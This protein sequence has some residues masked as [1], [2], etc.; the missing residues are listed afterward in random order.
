MAL[1]VL[2]MDVSIVIVSWN[3]KKHLEECL[4]G[5]YES[6]GSSFPEVIVVDNASTDGS[7]EMV[8]SRFR[9]VRLVR[10]EENLGFAK[11]NNIGIRLSKGRYIGLV[12]SDVKFLDGCLDALVTF[13]DR[14]PEVGVAGPRTLN[15]DMTLQSSCRRFPSLWNNFCSA[16]G[17]AR[18]LG[19]YPLFSGEHMFYFPHDRVMAVDVLVGCFWLLRR[20]AVQEVGLLDE[21]FFIFAEDLDWCRRCW[22]AG[23]QAVFCPEA[24]AIHHRGASSANDPV[25]FAVEQHRAMLHYWEKHHG[26]SG[27]LGIVSILLFGQLLRYLVAVASGLTRKSAESDSRLRMRMAAACLRTLISEGVVL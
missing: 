8:E 11:A 13:M 14:H 6:T 19:R 10:C 22:N 15:S 25:R 20:E 12:N 27:R 7:P 9:D 26:I 2:N 5:L 3:A 23:W 17:L 24:R 4:A 16:T 1:V 21:E 18:G